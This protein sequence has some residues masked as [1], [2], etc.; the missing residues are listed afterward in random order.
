MAGTGHSYEIGNLSRVRETLA[1][2]ME[3]FPEGAG[4]DWLGSRKVLRYLTSPEFTFPANAR[5]PEGQSALFDGDERDLLTAKLRAGGE[6]RLFSPEIFSMNHANGGG[7]GHVAD[8]IMWLSAN[9]RKLY[10]KL[11][12]INVEQ[13]I[14]RA[15][16]D[17]AGTSESRVPYGGGLEETVVDTPAGRRWVELL[18]RTALSAEGSAMKHCV[19]SYER[20]LGQHRIMSLR[21][22]RKRSLLTAEFQI[23]DGV[24]HLRQ[25]SAFANKAVP[26]H[27]QLCL[28]FLME[29]LGAADGPVAEAA[30]VC[31]GADGKWTRIVDSWERETWMGMDGVAS[32]SSLILMSPVDPSRTLLKVMFSSGDWRN[33]AKP[34]GQAFALEDRHFHIDEQRMVATVMNAVG[35]L[36]HGIRYVDVVFSDGR[37]VPQ[38]DLMEKREI[39]GVM[40]LVENQA[41]PADIEDSWP[42]RSGLE[43]SG[44]EIVHVV[45]SKD[46]ARTLLRIERDRSYERVKRLFA[47]PQDA[48]RWSPAEAKRCLAV[49]TALEIQSF[50]REIDSTECQALDRRYHPVRLASGRWIL[51]NEEAESLTSLTGCPGRGWKYVSEMAELS[52]GEYGS[53]SV[54][55][56]AKDEVNY[57][58]ATL[59]GLK[60]AAETA[61]FLNRMDWKPARRVFGGWSPQGDGSPV[62]YLM[63]RWRATV[64]VEGFIREATGGKRMRRIRRMQE[65]EAEAVFAVLPEAGGGDD[66]DFLLASAI[67]AWSRIAVKKEG[68]DMPLAPSPGYHYSAYAPRWSGTYEGR[69][70]AAKRLWHIF[71]D[72]T[73]RRLER[74]ASKA[75]RGLLKGWRKQYLHPAIPSVTAL[76]ET[77]HEAFSDALFE[78]TVK[79]ALSDRR[80]PL[81]PGV[82]APD[83]AW[84]GPLAERAVKSQCKWLLNE[85]C[86]Y[87]TSALKEDTVLTLA[88]AA[89][90]LECFRIASRLSWHF[91]ATRSAPTLLAAVEKAAQASPEEWRE[92]IEEARSLAELL[93]S[94]DGG[95][96]RVAA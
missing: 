5:D 52:T 10:A 53:V 17:W 63:G 20:F 55:K 87:T 81:K 34:T 27:A 9:D 68:S 88:D 96:N 84:F 25:V 19:G 42:W 73:R 2:L 44:N 72:T 16:E 76:L 4:R 66:A 94:R 64:D 83:P 36:G 62:Y 51:F 23:V 3:G 28:A 38:R 11:S 59:A 39:G 29:S 65:T 22:R 70:R 61:A 32:G 50:K 60:S 85:A 67:D 95:W 7:L 90:W 89:I 91:Q 46:S 6:V 69:L 54:R 15:G 56:N 41:R 79:K 35:H 31:R 21:D 26:D 74:V 1:R 49:M 14:L 37:H 77:Y 58:F 33:L 86:D 71:S 47:A 78:R 82:A 48:L 57:I 40:C 93:M 18:D 30:G 8:W 75:M 24:P 45:H 92:T 12:R 80:I 13:A 43:R